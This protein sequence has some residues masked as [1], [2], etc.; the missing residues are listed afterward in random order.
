VRKKG[1]SQ[2]T[3]R[4]P[5]QQHYPPTRAKRE[6]HERHEQARQ[7]RGPGTSHDTGRH[8]QRNHV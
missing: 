5:E 3:R 4:Q 2:A 8:E 6:L 1:A 7:Q